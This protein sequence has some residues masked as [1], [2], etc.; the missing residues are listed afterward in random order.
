MR[1]LPIKEIYCSC[2][3]VYYVILK[4]NKCVF[5]G[6]NHWR[7]TTTAALEIVTEIAAIEGKKIE[8]L[9]F[10]DLLTHYGWPAFKK[11]KYEFSEVIIEIKTKF[12]RKGGIS[13]R[14]IIQVLRWKKVPCPPQVLALFKERI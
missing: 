4:N 1:T 11:G 8:D 7:S 12:Y 6:G 13:P 5:S 14:K 2:G 10:F 9:R 3:K